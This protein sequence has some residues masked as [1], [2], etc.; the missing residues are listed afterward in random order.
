[1]ILYRLARR[2]HAKALDGFGAKLFPGRW[3]SLDVPMIY[4]AETIAQCM[5]EVLV[6]LEEIPDDYC[7]VELLV[8]D[9]VGIIHFDPKKLPRWWNDQD[10][11]TATRAV[12]DAFITANAGLLMRL[13]SAVVPGAYNYVMNPLHSDIKLVKV[14]NVRPFKFDKRLFK[15]P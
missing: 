12:G 8:P 3:N 11:N 9:D 5:V 6:H 2:K 7:S 13:P 4:C 1:M 15:H 14:G 10:Y